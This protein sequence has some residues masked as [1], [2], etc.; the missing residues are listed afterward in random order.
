VDDRSG[1]TLQQNVVMG[2]SMGG[3]VAR[4]ALAEMTKNSVDTET[5]LL[6]THD[7][8]HRGA[9]V[10]LG[11]Q[12]LIQMAGELDL[13]GFDARD[14]YPQYDEAINLLAEPATQQLL[15]YR[16]TGP[17]NFVNN[18]F[19]NGDYRSMI[20]FSPSDPQPSYRFIATSL[21]SECAHPLFEPYTQLI[22]INTN[23][24]ITYFPIVSYKIQTIIEAFGL[25]NAGS[26]SK[27]ARLK[28]AS[29]LSLFGIIPIVRDYYNNTAYAPGTQIPVD[30]APGSNNPLVE[31][32]VP[33]FS[34][35]LFW[36]GLFNLWILV[37][38]TTLGSPS[39]FTFVPAASALDVSPFNINALSQSY[40]NGFNQSFPSSSETF[41]AQETNTLAGIANNAHIRF[42]A[43][44]AEWLFNEMENLTNTENC[45]SECTYS[46]YIAGENSFCTGSTYSIPGLQN[47]AS[48]TWSA[49]PSGVVNLSCTTCNTVT[50][51]KVTDGYFQLRAS[52]TNACVAG[53]VLIRK[54]LVAGPPPATILG[55]YDP[56]EHTIMGI[57]CLGEEY[58]FE[59]ND[60]ETG[61]SYT[62][63]LFPPPGSSN[64][65][66]LHSGSTVYLTFIEL[67]YYTLRVSK[68]NSCGTTYTEMI[69]NVQECYG[70]R[71]MVSPNPAKGQVNVTID[72]KGNK[73]EVLEDIKME[74]LQFNTGA[75]QKQWSFGKSNQ[76]QF[77]LGLQ[78][79]RKGVYILKVTKGKQSRSVKIIIEE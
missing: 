54:N 61:Q 42:T 30:G 67:G 33:A 9:N 62:W 25:P 38:A 73:K 15:L 17:T 58:Y 12:Y 79:I 20:T 1:N 35:S 10:P 74:L 64:Y 5:R 13:F 53:P 46:Y 47:G 34:G 8:P 50:L 24:F 72:E 26:T 11:L 4:Y 63:T 57:A 49:S 39:V 29:K 45:S 65:P 52:I 23:A 48:V 66:T 68:T 36:P 28:L 32:D 59:A 37:N 40:V 41:I 77:T 78:G 69:I 6:I 22:N 18:N 76:K 51:T 56:V 31:F 55:P 43:R 19:L 75:K 44:N 27:I 21:G 70:L 7:S 2:L 14:V 16:A 3:L 71:M 60:I